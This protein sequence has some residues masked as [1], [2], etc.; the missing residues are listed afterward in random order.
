MYVYVCGSHVMSCD[1]Q[2]MSG[3]VVC[4][5]I[6]PE[7]RVLQN[8]W[9]IF[10]VQVTESLR[11]RLAKVVEACSLECGAAFFPHVCTQISN[12]MNM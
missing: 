12:A 10:L 6:L 7:V 8:N 2:V 9:H 5:T 3:D 4:L 11:M 1:S